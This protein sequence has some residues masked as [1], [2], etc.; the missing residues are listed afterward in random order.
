MFY[1]PN[2]CKFFHMW[3]LPQSH[4]NLVHRFTWGFFSEFKNMLQVTTYINFRLNINFLFAQEV[5]WYRFDFYTWLD[6]V[7]FKI[8]LPFCIGSHLLIKPVL[9]KNLSLLF[10]VLFHFAKKLTLRG[11][12]AT[13]PLPPWRAAGKR[14]RIKHL[15]LW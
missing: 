9:I 15:P 10:L 14:F 11:P 12:L 3:K 13:P 7:I 2:H 1:L 8:R 4:S 6:T 5:S